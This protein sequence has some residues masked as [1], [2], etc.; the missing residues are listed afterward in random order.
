M[1]DVTTMPSWDVMNNA[2]VC[3]FIDSLPPQ[4]MFLLTQD[5]R[6]YFQVIYGDPTCRKRLSKMTDVREICSYRSL[7]V[8]Y[9]AAVRGTSYEMVTDLSLDEFAKNDRVGKCCIRFL[10]RLLR[11]MKLVTN[12]SDFIVEKSCGWCGHGHAGSPNYMVGSQKPVHGHR[13]ITCLSCLKQFVM[14]DKEF[15]E[16][17]VPVVQ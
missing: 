3:K 12:N 4:D 2:E 15:R 13:C 11:R 8:A 6:K 14:N 9:T 1:D 17:V 16:Q 5:N 7:F 10:K